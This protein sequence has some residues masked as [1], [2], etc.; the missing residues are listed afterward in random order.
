MPEKVLTLL[1]KESLTEWQIAE[2]L[3]ASID[4]VKA[5]ME[6]L[7]QMGYIKSTFINPSGSGSCHDN[8][9]SHFS[10]CGNCS[11][12]CGGGCK[13]C[14]SSENSISNSSYTVGEIM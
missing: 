14:G 6:Y 4:E 1:E 9:N 7:Q 3:H 5:V 10:G 13:G 12:G 2:K 8:S 11:G